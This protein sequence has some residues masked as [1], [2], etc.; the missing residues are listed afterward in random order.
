MKFKLFLSTG[1]LFMASS[2]F[3][4]IAYANDFG[5]EVGIRQQS[6][7]SP[8]SGVNVKSKMGYQFGGVAHFEIQGPVYFRTG[9]LYTQRPITFEIPATNVTQQYSLNSVDVPLTALYK[10]QDY[11]GAFAGLVLSMN[12]DSTCSPGCSVTNVK[13]PVTPFIFGANFKFAPELAATLYF[14]TGGKLADGIEDNRA[15]GA[16]LMVTFD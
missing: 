15:V 2:A 4:Y 7:S 6:A 12:L 13:S 10:F 1:L 11:A 8:T 16:N 9:L 14:E 5:L 3:S